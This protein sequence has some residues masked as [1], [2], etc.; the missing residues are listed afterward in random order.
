MREIKFRAWI[1]GEDDGLMI[2]QGDKSDFTM[3]SNG[4]DFS[5]VV[6]HEEWLKPNA[7]EIMQYTG[8]KDRN[9]VE[10]FEGDLIKDH[11]GVGVV[12]WSD[13]NASLKVSYIGESKGLGK[14]FADYNLKGERES[15]EVI[16]NI[17]E[18]HELLECEA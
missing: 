7:F 1:K 16:G 15:I 4:G 6:D 13:K 10:I 17:H 5:I 2:H 12:V 9:G 11:I 18:N 8:H 3:V 14:W